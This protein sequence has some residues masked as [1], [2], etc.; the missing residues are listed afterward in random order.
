MTG[1]FDGHTS[2]ALKN[3]EA[4]EHL[5]KSR[6]SCRAFRPES[7][8]QTTI[9]RLLRLAQSAPSWCNMQPWQITVVS[10]VEREL[11]RDRLLTCFDKGKP[12]Q[13]DYIFPSSYPGIYGDRRRVSGFQL[14][15]AIGVERADK[16]RHRQE[17]RRNFS[18][19]DAPHVAII[20][21]REELGTYGAVDCGLFISHFLL[22]AEVM[23]I[24]AVAQAALALYSAEIR[25]QLEIDA[26]RR[27]I[28][29]ISFGRPDRS[30][31]I[32]QFRTNRADLTETTR[33]F[34]SDEEHHSESPLSSA[35]NS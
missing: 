20:C 14:Y 19:F 25:E 3:T 6:H 10:G 35:R 34:G 8:P 30:H 5:L 28:C 11:L 27:I 23:G 1:S 33:F 22:T 15:D 4:L 2:P 29:G 18:F 24:G 7:L 21:T 13:P 12:T 9:E 26:S 31:K 32:N 16:V 17:I